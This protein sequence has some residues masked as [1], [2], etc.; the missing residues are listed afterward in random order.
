MRQEFSPREREMPKGHTLDLLVSMEM[1]LNL[2]D[3]M[4]CA[5]KKRLA[6]TDCLLWTIQIIGNFTLPIN[7][8]Y[9]N[10]KL[11]M[12]NFYSSR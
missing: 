4:I 12:K 7:I 9:N 5:K 3:C 6:Q 10:L 8:L 1:K 2:H 11:S